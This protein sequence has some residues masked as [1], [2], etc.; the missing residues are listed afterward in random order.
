MTSS[1]A[2]TEAINPRY[3]DLDAWDA[4]AI[5][6]A[7]WEGQLA[8]AAAV[9]AALPAIAAAANAAAARLAGGQGRLVY[10][11]AGTSGRIGVQDGAE[12]APT[13]DWPATRLVLLMA[14]GDAAFTTSIE[15]AED[16]SDAG[17]AAIGTHG[18]GPADVVLGIAASGGTP[19][20]TA[21]LRAAAARG[22]LTIGVANAPGGS[23]LACAEH[24][25]LVETGAE[26][27]AGSTRMKAGTAQKIVLNLFSS[28]LMVQLG[29]V[30]QGLMVDM[31]A[32]NEKLRRRA[33]RML[34]HLTGI[35][36]EATL[37]T[38]L[39]G[40][41]GRVKT[42]VLLL[43]GLDRAQAETLLRRCG[44]RLRTALTEIAR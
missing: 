1:A 32:R 2:A 41:D 38:A 15:N 40:A 17:A 27:I 10:A 42:A 43:H 25:V 28:L 37:H 33:M 4:P 20:T 3:R 36:D 39:A 8:A 6:Q 24:K 14:G 7:M 34:R 13:F 44:D 22:A 21:V 19:F 23:L 11:G 30:H 18:I 26:V 5:L 35:D 12:L 29:R 31:Q 16:D 9:H